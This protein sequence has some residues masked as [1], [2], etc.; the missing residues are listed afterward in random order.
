MICF[1][2]PW[3]CPDPPILAFLDPCFFPLHFSLAFLERKPLLFSKNLAFLK[4]HGFLK[5][6]GFFG[7]E[8]VL[9]L[10]PVTL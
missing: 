9:H 1:A 5:K 7:V 10:N 2:I 4:K 3:T 6:Q 8:F